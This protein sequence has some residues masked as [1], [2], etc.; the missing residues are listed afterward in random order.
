MGKINSEKIKLLKNLLAKHGMVGPELEQAFEAFMKKQKKQERKNIP[1]LT[2]LHGSGKQIKEDAIAEKQNAETPTPVKSRKTPGKFCATCRFYKWWGNHDQTECSNPNTPYSDPA[3]W[4]LCEKYANVEKRDHR[5][6]R[7]KLFARYMEEISDRIDATIGGAVQRIAG[8]VA[9]DAATLNLGYIEMAEIYIYLAAYSFPYGFLE[10][11][12]EGYNYINP[13]T[14]QTMLTRFL[15]NAAMNTIKP[16]II[17]CKTCKHY[18][19]NPASKIATGFCGRNESL[20]FRT[21]NDAF[22]SFFV[23]KKNDGGK[24]NDG[25]TD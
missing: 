17:K 18:K 11:I 9:A 8:E 12:G 25:K 20:R 24:N 7:L 10:D 6:D 22:C 19:P 3:P 23:H 5:D 16:G 21:D 1:R 15:A 2:G 13:S 4:H 14:E